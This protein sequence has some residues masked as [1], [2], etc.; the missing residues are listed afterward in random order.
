MA[1]PEELAVIIERAVAAG[2]RMALRD[3]PTP[4]TSSE[5]TTSLP[6][7]STEIMRFIK[8]RGHVNLAIVA[9]IMSPVTSLP[10]ASS[11]L[12]HLTLALCLVKI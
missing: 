7:V 9:S 11:C 10:F 12:T 2:V 4:S 1:S 3:R 8:W 5:T 6:S